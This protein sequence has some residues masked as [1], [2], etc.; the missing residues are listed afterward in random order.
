MKDLGKIALV[1]G[2]NRGIGFEVC[3]I[4][5]EKGYTVLLTATDIDKAKISASKISEEIRYYQLDVTDNQSIKKARHAITKDYNIVDVLVNNAGILND[6]HADIKTYE[7]QK[8]LES[9]N[10]NAIGPLNVLTEFSPLL[11]KS[12]KP[13]VINVS[14]IMGSIAKADGTR[15]PGY[16]ASKAVLNLYTKMMA[17]AYP[18]MKIISLHPGWCQT[19]MG[20]KK[21]PETARDGAEKILKAI[22]VIDELESGAFYNDNKKEEF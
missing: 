17:K 3:R 5:Y 4:L 2:G 7:S 9:I 16:R 11:Q 10:T 1:T 13:L 6:F 12:K 15:C 22:E 14:S 21:A 18:D 8:I 20:G 19:E